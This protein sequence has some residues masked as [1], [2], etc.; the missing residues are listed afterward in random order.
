MKMS[1]DKKSKIITGAS[2]GIR[3]GYPKTSLRTSSTISTNHKRRISKRPRHGLALNE[4]ITNISEDYSRRI[5]GE[6]GKYYRVVLIAFRETLRLDNYANR[7]GELYSFLPMFEENLFHG[8]VKQTFEIF[9]L[10]YIFS[11]ESF[12]YKLHKS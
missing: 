11:D 12:T 10:L 5:S 1:I 7:L 8:K 9:R 3:C 4:Y 6:L 2:A